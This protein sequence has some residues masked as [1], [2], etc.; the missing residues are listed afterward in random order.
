M[1]EI[2]CKGLLFDM[3]G[4]LVDS[5][6]AVEQT[7][8]DWCKKQGIEP[9]EFFQHSHG[10]RTQDNIK[11]FQTQPVPGHT[12]SEEEL[13]KAVKELEF[14]IADNGR[15]MH[16][17]GGK[18][19]ERLPGVSELLDALRKG[20]A[21]WG[22]CTSATRLYAD[23]ALV[24]GEIGS[25]PPALPFLITGDICEHGK[26]HP[27]PYLRG[28]DELRKLSGPDFDASEILVVEDAPSGLKSGLAAGCK[29]LGVATGQPMERFKTFEASY[30]VVDLT[31]V[32]VMSASPEGVT[33]RLKLLD[34]E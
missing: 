3:D 12:L 6:P 1:I 32:E 15:K 27:E 25:M 22:I 5:T 26:P 17:A 13:D 11:R 21:R 4:T 10:V 28:M 29:T 7:M 31:R 2:T 16:E 19:I 20:G 33:L 24:T 14:L 9:S 30:K 18:G 23:S 8:G 34:E